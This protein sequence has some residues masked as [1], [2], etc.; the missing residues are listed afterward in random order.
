MSNILPIRTNYYFQGEINPHDLTLLKTWVE[1]L[2]KETP[3]TTLELDEFLNKV[4]ELNHK[5][6]D[7]GG[8][9]YIKMTCDTIDKKIVEDY[10]AFQQNISAYYAPK[11]FAFKNIVLNSPALKDWVVEHGKTGSLLER[12]LKNDSDLFREENVALEIKENELGIEYRS[13]TGSMTVEFNGE[14]K[15]LPEMAIFLKDKDRN[16]REK[17]WRV[18]SEKMLTHKDELNVLFNK[19]YELRQ[20]IAKNAGFDNYRDYMHQAKGR[21]SYTVQDIH[22]FH[23][24]VESEIMPLIAELNQKRKDTLQIDNLKPWDMSVS[25]DGKLLK[26]VKKTE[27]LIPKHIT[28]M[29]QIDPIF[30]ENFSSMDASK[31]LDLFNRKNKAPGGY[32]Y[33]L[34]KY[35]ASFIFMNAVGLHSDLTTLIHEIGHAMHEFAQADHKYS[36]LLGL[37]MEAA[38]LASMSMEMISMDRW[39]ECYTDKEDFRK[40]K[41]DQIEGALKFF[42]WCMTIDSFQQK[43]YT[44][45][46]TTELREQAF[47]DVMDRFSNKAGLNWSGLEQERAIQ[48]LFQ[49]HI[50]EVPFYYIEYGIAQLGAL[51]V[52]REYK[53]NPKIAVE[54]YKKFLNI[55]HQ[56]PL[57]DIYK[58]AGIELKFTK[59]YIRELV[60]FVREELKELS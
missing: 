22:N 19:L 15:T 30:G 31:L 7:T 39:K 25:L 41:Y 47:I 55:G 57:A 21:F 6:R 1:Q 59:E 40:A 3:K 29:Q 5:I 52:Y 58:I 24:A 43:I 17:A 37:P 49:L 4:D 14:E 36:S 12:I 48:W 28:M 46:G 32:S 35:G 42:P 27:D 13:I 54:N 23:D 20:E 38:E 44:D 26:P 18:R 10:T 53:Q 8:E 50:F 60:Q 11:D 34:Y 33:P 9:I 16:V 2:E 56:V 51:A 45:S